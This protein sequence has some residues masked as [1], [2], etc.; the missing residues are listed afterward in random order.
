MAQQ[1]DD[2]SRPNGDQ[3]NAVGNRVEKALADN[4]PTPPESELHDRADFL[5]GSW[6]RVTHIHVHKTRPRVHI[7]FAAHRVLR[8]GK[9][10]H[11]TPTE[12]KVLLSL[13]ARAETVVLYADLLTEGWDET[14]VGNGIKDLRTFISVLRRK[15]EPEF[16][17]PR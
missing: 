7:D 3:G 4:A 16:T 1:F 17:K 5:Q 11:L 12:L 15:L 8:D 2:L 13:A 9:E 10:V 6:D 14:Y